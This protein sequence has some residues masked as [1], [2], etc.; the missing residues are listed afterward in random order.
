M[1]PVLVLASACLLIVSGCLGDGASTTSTD[2][3]AG[4]MLRLPGMPGDPCKSTCDCGFGLAC[5]TGR[6]TPSARIE[7]CCERPMCPPGNK[8]QDATGNFS[9]CPGMV[10]MPDMAMMM[11]PMPD[12]GRPPMGDMTM[13]P[14]N[15]G[16]MMGP[17]SC[18]SNNDCPLAA[19]PQGS[20]GCTCSTTPM[21]MLC[22]PTCTVAADCPMMNPAFQCRNGVCAP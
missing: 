5:D 7:Y 15:D 19:C 22:V 14:P 9:V 1:R 20:K 21:G 18:Q 2:M 10:P 11:P 17:K 4:D 6:C 3:A 12:M 8:C 16:G 13:P